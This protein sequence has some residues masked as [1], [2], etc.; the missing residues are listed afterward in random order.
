MTRD[1]SK[2]WQVFIS[3]KV[4]DGKGGYTRDWHLA[5]E[6]YELLEANSI[7]VFMSS[8]SLGQLGE[9]DYKQVIEEALEQA[10]VM[11]VV[12][13]SKENINS[14][15][16]KYEWNSFH[17]EIISGIKKGGRVFAFVETLRIHELPRP[18]RNNQSFYVSERSSLVSFVISALGL[19]S[20]NLTPKSE[21]EQK[22]IA[23]STGHDSISL[24]QK[25]ESELAI[26]SITSRNGDELIYVEGGVFIMGDTWGDG[27]DKEKPPHEVELTYDFYIGKCPVTFD[28]YD[29]FCREI[30][31]EEPSDSGLG[32]GRKPV[33]WVSW[34]DAIEYCNWLSEKEGLP[35][36][37]SGDGSLLDRN[38]QETEDITKVKGY[39]LLTE[40]EWEYSARGGKKSMGYKYA[41]SNSPDLVA[42]YDSNSGRMIHEVGQKKCNELGLY[43]MSG[44]VWEWCCDCYD[45]EYY[46]R[47]PSINPYNS[48]DGSS[49]VKRGGSWLDYALCV[50]VAFR[51][52]DTPDYKYFDFGFRIARTVF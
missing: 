49:R 9:S 22:K 5:K 48:T 4:S 18:L 40:A 16:V 25:T 1:S 12:G 23:T 33:M 47:S 17:N 30:E 19:D 2:D 51:L 21:S 45:S 35:I 3:C 20:T 8:I 50:R 6:L 52:D 38:K 29:R 13:T 42:W 28:E 26:K 11:V 24:Q 44:N 27:F 15:Y 36:S 14:E 31:T 32:R 39:R 34:F 46:S 43:D 7:K 10:Q 37:Y 41:G